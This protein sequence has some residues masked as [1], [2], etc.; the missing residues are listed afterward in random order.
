[1]KFFQGH[2]SKIF[3]LS[4]LVV[5][6]ITRTSKLNNN[7]CQ[8]DGIYSLELFVK[9]NFTILNNYTTNEGKLDILKLDKNITRAAQRYS[10]LCP[11]SNRQNII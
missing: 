4:F 7:I 10:T 2:I 11:E 1:M 8:I 3:I 5:L 6:I 9:I